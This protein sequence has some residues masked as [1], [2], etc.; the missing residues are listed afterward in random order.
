MEKD[1]QLKLSTRMKLLFSI[2]KKESK[3]GTMSTRQV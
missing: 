1:G 3:M 2:A